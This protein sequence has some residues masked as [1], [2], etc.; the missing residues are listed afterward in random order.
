MK[1]SPPDARASH[2][3]PDPVDKCFL[4]VHP[5]RG[6]SIFFLTQSLS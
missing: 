1:R 6:T 2:S 4:Q 3:D 5:E